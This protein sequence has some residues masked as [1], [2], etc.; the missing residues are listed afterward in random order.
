MDGAGLTEGCW[1]KSEVLGQTDDLE[2][3][4]LGSKVIGATFFFKWQ[5][6]QA[7]AGW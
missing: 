3:E 2:A 5:F 6:G 7:E 1:N 4:T